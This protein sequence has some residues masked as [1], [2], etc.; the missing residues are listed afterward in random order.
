MTKR[1][2]VLTGGG[3]VP[4]LN[5][6]IQELTV[7]GNSE[8]YEVIGIRRGWGGLIYMSP[9]EQDIDPQH[10]LILTP[11][12]VR[13][14]DREGGTFLHTSRVNP[15]KASADRRFERYRGF[16]FEGKRNLTEDVQKN[17]KKM[18]IDV[19]IAIGGDDTLTY[20]RYLAAMGFDVVGI[21]KTMDGDVYGAGECIG[22]STSITR[23]N[24]YITQ[25]RTPAGSHERVAVLE[26]FGR[27]S[28][29]TAIH[30]ALAANPDRVLIPEVPFDIGRVVELIGRDYDANPSQYAMLLVA[31]GAKS[32][33]GDV[34]YQ[35]DRQDQYDH[36]KLGGIGKQVS[37]ALNNAGFETIEN[38][39][40]YLIRSGVPD[41]HDKILARMY[42]HAAIDAVKRGK[43]GTLTARVDGSFTLVPLEITKN[44]PLTVDV[45]EMYDS[46]LYRPKPVGFMKGG[47][48][49]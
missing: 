41:A 39:L 2:G 19:I 1:I 13:K 5:A 3:D 16:M 38:L 14:I 27:H 21:P 44:S 32:A 34:V 26:Q 23:S 12:M 8:G 40:T 36:K 30:S 20:A 46:Q 7:E 45:A 6:V 42:A 11:D 10:A 18:G 24:E 17:L 4:G 9:D 43:T 47:L 15:E 22:F 35:G 49:L 33:S 29:L 48:L 28:G 31:E 37:E 25:L